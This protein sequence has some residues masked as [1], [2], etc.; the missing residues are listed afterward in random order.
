M[1]DALTSPTP[2]SPVKFE[3]STNVPTTHGTFQMRS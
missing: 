2:G 3:V 1:T